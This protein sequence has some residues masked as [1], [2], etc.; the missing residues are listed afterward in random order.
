MNRLVASIELVKHAN[1]RVSERNILHLHLLRY[2][3]LHWCQSSF[4]SKFI[5]A[6]NGLMLQIRN[7]KPND[8]H[9][10]NN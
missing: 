4:R 7:S 8:M 9:Y 3:G 6:Q 10:T 1:H 5:P 2:Y